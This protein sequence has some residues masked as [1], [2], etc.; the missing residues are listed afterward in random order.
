MPEPRYVKVL[1]AGQL[2][3]G[4]GKV[5]D[6][7]GR[8]V[9]VYN[10][11]GTH[12][13]IDDLCPHMG[14]S[15][16]D[17]PLEGDLATC[18]WH[19][20]QF[21]V[22]SGQCTDAPRVRVPCYAVLEKADGIYVALVPPRSDIMQNTSKKPDSFKITIAHSPDPDDAFMFWAL[23]A[24]RI[25]SDNIAVTHE[26]SDIQ[27]LNQRAMQGVHE[28][29]AVSIHAYAY[30]TDKYALATCGASVGDGYGPMVVAT[31]GWTLD[32]LKGLPIAIPGELTTAYLALRLMLP[33]AKVQVMPFDQIME[34]VESGAVPAGLIIHEGQLTWKERGL[35]QL[36]DLGV[37]WKDKT[38]LP[39]PL[40]GNA[41]RKDLGPERMERVARLMRR[42]IDYGLDHR[43]E[44]LQHA[45][46]W[47]RG[48]DRGKADTFVSMYVND[49]TRDYGDKG[50]QAVRL[51]L[52]EA[53]KA[54]I[55]PRAVE[56]EFVQS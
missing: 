23:A 32:R 45:L 2:A 22:K 30:L 10:V 49:Y 55:V 21:S 38:G 35:T 40:G 11:G 25:D 29:S 47:G 27:T 17:G 12:H 46:K 56:P 16:G 20:W 13:A 3:P 28:V 19:G 42:S 14:G 33:E 7:E 36:V 39:L 31:P 53:H 37:W 34:A 6:V 26:L 51:L 5:V 9:A 54:G 50:R 48:I 52:S 44:A 15:I 24:D 18:P 1:E 41:I 43:D 8:N 4:Q